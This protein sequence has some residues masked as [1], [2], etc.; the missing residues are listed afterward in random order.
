M[1]YIGCL[2]IFI[3]FCWNHALF[4]EEHFQILSFL[5]FKCNVFPSLARRTCV[6]WIVHLF[7][8]QMTFVTPMKHIIILRRKNMVFVI[9]Q[10]NV[11]IEVEFIDLTV[12]PDLDLA[13]CVSI[14]TS[15]KH[16]NI[17]LVIVVRPSLFTFY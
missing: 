14:T 6:S 10:R 11:M 8:F 7:S 4:K 13:V 17:Y 12:P 2:V 9:P 16:C 3:F 1:L 5:S 15:Y